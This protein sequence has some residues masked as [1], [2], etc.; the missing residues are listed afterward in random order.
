MSEKILCV[1]TES[2]ALALVRK[3]FAEPEF[4]VIP[5]VRSKTGFGS[6]RTADALAMGM[7]PSRG[8][9][10]HGIEI[11]V[12]R[13]DWLAELK[14]PAKAE[15]IAQY[16]DFW[17]VVA[18]IADIVRSEE[19][20]DNWGLLV[21]SSRNGLR[22]VKE[23]IRLTPEPIPRG[24]LAALLRSTVEWSRS[25]EEVQAAKQEASA[26]LEESHKRAVEFYKNNLTKEQ[27]NSRELHAQLSLFVGGMYMA[28]ETLKKKA[29]EFRVFLAASPS[30]I[31]RAATIVTDAAA[32][33]RDLAAQTDEA[34]QSFAAFAQ[35][36]A[37]AT[38]A[39]E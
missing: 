35:A 4:L 22:V 39:T 34:A 9:Y 30:A 1:T 37:P 33:L 17:W 23:A 19:L 29:D 15:R 2:G 32:R 7:W 26:R 8:V 28:P 13:S 12:S 36:V 24:F 3:H 6:A 20:P 21:P 31:Q 5:Q 11:K 27:K 25:S 38:G 16:C 18:G 10:L 14:S